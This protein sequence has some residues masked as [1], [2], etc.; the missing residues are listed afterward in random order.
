MMEV[1][2]SLPQM[3]ELMTE[4]EYDRPV[5]SA[6]WET[7]WPQTVEEFDR[8]VVAFQDRL[9]RYAYRRLGNLGDAEDVAQE[10]FLRAYADRGQ[11]KTVANVGAYLYRMAANLATDLVRRRKGQTVSLEEVSGIFE[12]PSQHPSACRIAAAAEEIQRIESLLRSVPRDQAE[13]IR[14]RVLD[15]LP[16]RTIAEVLDCPLTTVKSRL[17]YGLEALREIVIRNREMYQ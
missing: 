1:T 2:E 8:L 13:A 7:S 17:R 12:I 9:V 4:P 14:L 11:R 10:V 15:E 5:Q 6:V 16:P 3:G